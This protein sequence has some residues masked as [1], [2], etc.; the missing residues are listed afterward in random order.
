MNRCIII[1]S[2]QSAPI[3][4]FFQFQTDD[5][6]I[7]ADGGYSFARA[8]GITPHVIIGDFDSMEIDTKEN[9]ISNCKVIRLAPE[10]D[11][12]DTMVCLNYGIENGFDEF[13]ILGGLGGRL[14]HTFANLQTMSHAIDQ[15]KSIWFLDGKNSATM[16][17]PEKF[18][19]YRKAGFKISLFAFTDFCEGVCIHGVKYPLENCLLTNSFPLGVSNEFL[20][21]IAEISHSSG[22]LL[23]ILS[24][25]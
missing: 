16:K 9:D 5:Y 17:N 13:F 12:T 6:V 19:I 24:Q 20:E 2:F 11:D 10:K 15:K 4:E 1:T 21:D 22:K 8:E 25:D 3:K 18:S 14:D 23:V 7:C